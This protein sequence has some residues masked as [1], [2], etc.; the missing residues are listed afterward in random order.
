MTQST[1]LSELVE[2]VLPEGVRPAPRDLAAERARDMRRIAEG[3]VR[4]AGLYGAYAT[5]D[6]PAGRDAYR[7]FLAGRGTYLFGQPGVG[8]TYAAACCVRLALESGRRAKLVSV[9]SLLEAVKAGYDG[10]DRAVLDRAKGYDLLVLDDLGME[11]ATA[12]SMETLSSLV[13]HRVS[14]GLPTVV[15]SNYGLGQLRDRW[16]GMEGNRLAS[17]LAGACGRVELK[18]ADRRLS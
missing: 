14:R 5:A 16:G 1:R 6:S 10:G 11:R 13:D 2:G 18:G 4:K 8:K 15:T 9:P 17:R 3:R 12:W 7:R